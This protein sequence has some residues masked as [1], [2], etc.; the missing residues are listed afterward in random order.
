ML[1]EG[2]RVFWGEIMQ[3]IVTKASI[4]QSMPVEAPWLIELICTHFGDE[5]ECEIEII[6]ES[7]VGHCKSL[8]GFNSTNPVDLF[9]KLDEIMKS[10]KSKEPHGQYTGF[11]YGA[12]DRAQVIAEARKLY[13]KAR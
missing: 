3:A 2:A 10:C 1:Y 12:L 4:M 5:S 6:H 7:F 9:K 11:V 13:T 8:Y